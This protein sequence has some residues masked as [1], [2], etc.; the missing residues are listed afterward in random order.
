[1]EINHFQ[2]RHFAGIFSG[3]VSSPQLDILGKREGIE[4]SI[5]NFIL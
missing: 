4:L 5:L 2:F 3:T 1:M